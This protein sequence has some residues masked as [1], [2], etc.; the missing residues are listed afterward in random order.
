MTA[1]SEE[2]KGIDFAVES[3][4]STMH[5]EG[6]SRWPQRDQPHTAAGINADMVARGS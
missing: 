4:E 6:A 3:D 2:I 1:S 5:V